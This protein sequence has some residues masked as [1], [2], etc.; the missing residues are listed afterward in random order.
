M[1]DEDMLKAYAAGFID[2]EGTITISTC[3]HRGKTRLQPRFTIANTEVEPLVVMQTILGGKVKISTKSENPNHKQCYVLE[4]G[5]MKDI[6]DAI[7][8][9][10]P[11][12]I[13]KKR[14]AQIVKSFIVRRRKEVKAIPLITIRPGR[15]RFERQRLK[16][17]NDEF[18]FK[19]AA[20]VQT[21]NKRGV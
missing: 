6:L 18:E 4:I 2:G 21:L 19:L 11:F 1:C 9:V 17:P 3:K 8:A 13:I 15:N 7:D 12:L 20:D 14:Q 16:R 10:L 5:S